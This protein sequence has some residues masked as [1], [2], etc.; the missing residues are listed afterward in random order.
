[1]ATVAEQ[2]GAAPLVG[3]GATTLHSHAGAGPALE[4][5]VAVDPPS[6]AKGTTVNVDVLVAGLLITHKI[7]V[8]C[9]SDF[10]HGLACI[11]AY[12]PVD[13]TLRL[14]LSNWSA[15]AVDGAART[16]AFQAYA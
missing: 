12:C 14:R 6:I 13:G 7:Y 5:T 16:W 11:A 4:G 9:Q 10:E 8:Q 3:G 15:D 1:M 2:V